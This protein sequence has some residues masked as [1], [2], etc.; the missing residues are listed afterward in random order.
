[1]YLG[2]IQWYFGLIQRYFGKIQWYFGRI[3]RYYGKIQW[4]FR[5]NTKVL[6]KKNVAFMG[7]IDIVVFW[8]KNRGFCLN[9]VIFG[10]KYSD[11]RGKYSGIK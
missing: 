5:A 9:T 10:G 3:Q 1:M 8:G 6:G 2:Q 7:Q 4:H 11:I